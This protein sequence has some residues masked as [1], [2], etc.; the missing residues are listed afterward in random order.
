[1]TDAVVTWVDGADP[2]HARKLAHYL[3]G[4]QADIEQEAVSDERF[5]QSNELKYC[6]R[7][8]YNH[9]PWID[10]VFVITDNQQPDFID[11]AEARKSDIFFVSH[12]DI[13]WD[14]EHFLPTFNSRSIETMMWRFPSLSENFVYLND[15]T[16][17]GK[18]T[19]KEDFFR[20]DIPIPSGKWKLIPKTPTLHQLGLINASRMIWPETDHYFHLEHTINPLSRTL[21]EELHD[22]IGP[23]FLDNAA[24]RFRNAEQFQPVAGLFNHVLQ[25]G[26]RT[27][28]K[29]SLFNYKLRTKSVRTNSISFQLK[30]LLFRQNFYKTACL[31]DLQEQLK[32]CPNLLTWISKA[33][34]PPAPFELNTSESVR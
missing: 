26:I 6:L 19:K 10:R 12:E 13:F 34:G 24:Y 20:S 29:T 33:T 31:N 22:S 32:H 14:Y 3:S 1:M 23:G 17:F 25:K 9:A 18:K 28:S 5:L 2:A 21:F 30:S 11:I 15:D 7:S 8:I 16:F 4:Q 27:R